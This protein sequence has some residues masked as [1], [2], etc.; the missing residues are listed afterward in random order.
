[1]VKRALLFW[2]V[3]AAV[4]VANGTVRQLG[5]G[6]H[7]DPDAA[8]VVSCFTAIALIM[9]ATRIYAAWEGPRL[10]PGR[11]GA[12]GASW[13][14]LTILFEFG[15]GHYVMGHPWSRLLADYDFTAGRLW[16]LVLASIGITP[17]LWVRPRP[18]RARASAA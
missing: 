2:V 18:A 9:V 7:M 13:V 11:A 1:M 3:L 4:G 5:Y 14:A 17:W 8:H 16:V 6:P 12:V 10:T 15:F